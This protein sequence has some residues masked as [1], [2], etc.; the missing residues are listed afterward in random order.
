MRNFIFQMLAFEK[1]AGQGWR[2]T[3]KTKTIMST[4]TIAI[5]TGPTIPMRRIKSRSP[6]VVRGTL[7]SWAMITPMEP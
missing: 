5:I 3:R 4:I 7:S 2:A 1:M 6:F